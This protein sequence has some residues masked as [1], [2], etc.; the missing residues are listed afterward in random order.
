[1]SISK[2]NLEKFKLLAF[3]AGKHSDLISF[4]T[5]EALDKFKGISKAVKDIKD[6]ISK[7]SLIEDSF[8]IQGETGTGKELLARASHG[9]RIGE[10]IPVNCAAL[11]E[12][13]AEAELFGTT[14]GSYT[15]NCGTTKG[16]IRCARDGTL[17]LDEI[18]DLPLGI[19][20]KLL[21]FCQD[22]MVRS[23]GS[24]ELEYVPTR[25]VCASHKILSG[26]TTFRKDLFFRLAR[27]TITIPPL[28]DRREDIPVLFEHFLEDHSEI[29]KLVSMLS[30]DITGNV[31]EIESLARIY[32]LFGKDIFGNT[33]CS[34]H[35]GEWKNNPED[36]SKKS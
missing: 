28:R 17:F 34:P 1:M 5:R 19:Q 6:M 15:G 14:K 31:R 26:S 16:L 27:I 33:V 7:L 30:P 25:I 36:S 13:L 32:Q 3:Q 24:T 29:A 18:G 21:R 23:I 22:G 4:L 20:A 2:E 35:W 8:L 10:F 9:S 12:S 11:Q